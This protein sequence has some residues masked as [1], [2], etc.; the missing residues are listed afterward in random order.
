M[1][2]LDEAAPPVDEPESQL[3][4]QVTLR[5][6]RLA[7]VESVLRASGARRV[8]DLGCGPGALLE[9][10]LSDD[11]ELIVGADVSVRALERASRRLKLDE[12]HE[13]Q[14]RRITLLH[15]P[16]TYRDK[17]PGRF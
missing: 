17:R 4:A 12:M 9:R 14:R 2:Q 10:L 7:A 11:Y 15:S 13:V 3:D 5:D 6:Q 1:A 16:L 8:L